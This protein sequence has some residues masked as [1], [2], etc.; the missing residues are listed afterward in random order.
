MLNLIASD[1]R[2]SPFC[3]PKQKDACSTTDAFAKRKRALYYSICVFLLS[4]IPSSLQRLNSRSDTAVLEED[5][6]AVICLSN[7]ALSEPR[8]ASTG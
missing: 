1:R 8:G 3:N 6:V 4:A 7:L 2:Y 5:S